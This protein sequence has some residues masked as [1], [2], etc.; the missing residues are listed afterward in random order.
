MAII[1]GPPARPSFTGLG[2]PGKAKGMLPKT[3][4]TRMPIKMDAMFGW[5]SRFTELPNRRVTRFTASSGP[6]TIRRSPICRRF[7]KSSMPER[8]TRVTFTP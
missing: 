7:A 2:M 1:S 5:S 6:T 3:M 4:P 8:V